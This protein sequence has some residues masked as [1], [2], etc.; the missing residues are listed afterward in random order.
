LINKHGWERA[1]KVAGQILA[2]YGALTLFVVGV[3]WI[4]S[5]V[6]A[7]DAVGIVR[8]ICDPY[9]FYPMR[10]R[11]SAQLSHD[12]RLVGATILATKEV[13][14]ARFRAVGLRA[15]LE[16]DVLSKSISV[17]EKTAFLKSLPTGVIRGPIVSA[18]LPSIP[19]DEKV[20]VLGI[21]MFDE[22]S[23]LCVSSDSLGVIATNGRLLHSDPSFLSIQGFPRFSLDAELLVWLLCISVVVGI[24]LLIWRRVSRRAAA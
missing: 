18:T 22:G 11:D 19:P 17:E 8:I 3:Q 16:W 21:A 6:F 15:I 10:G 13:E 14:G 2:V 23:Q 9:A 12:W 7:T 4:Y 1:A 24:S 5:K 20:S